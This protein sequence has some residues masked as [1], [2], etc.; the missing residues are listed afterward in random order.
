[1]KIMYVLLALALF[2]G[3]AVPTLEN[4]AAPDRAAAAATLDAGSVAK[5]VLTAKYDNLLRKTVMTAA[6]DFGSGPLPISVYI[7]FYADN[8]MLAMVPHTQIGKVLLK[9]GQAVLTTVQKPGTYHAMAVW[10]NAPGG[11]RCSQIVRYLV[12]GIYLNQ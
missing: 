1:M 4:T 3:C 7:D 11:R 5:L 9:N 10:E 12:P 6:L 2:S 8:A